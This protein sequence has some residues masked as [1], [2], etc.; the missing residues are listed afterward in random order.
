[1]NYT[2]IAQMFLN[3]VSKHGN[4]EIFYYK[5]GRDWSSING[6]TILYTV[7]DISNAI[8]IIY[9]YFPYTKL[10]GLFNYFFYIG[11]S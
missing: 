4:K 8:F 9:D 7:N 1:M 6:K 3:T 10:S 11:I 5:K 2:T